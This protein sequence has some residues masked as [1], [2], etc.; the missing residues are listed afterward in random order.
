MV[1]TADLL[2]VAI[3]IALLHNIPIV[4]FMSTGTVLIA[5]QHSGQ[6]S[7]F[8]IIPIIGSRRGYVFPVQNFIFIFIHLTF[9]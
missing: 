2:V 1:G 3:A 5:T 4:G 7:S 6:K 9:N 8:L